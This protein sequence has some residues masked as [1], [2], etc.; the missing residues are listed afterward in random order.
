MFLAPVL[1]AIHA[2]LTGIAMALM[3]AIGVHLG[4][5]FSAG[6]FDYVL[7]YS[8]S[9][10]P[11]LL[12]PVGLAYFALYYGLF[13]FFI[14]RFDLKTLGREAD[15]AAAPR[16]EPAG[17]AAPAYAWINALGSAS[18]LL[19]VEACATRLRLVVARFRA[20]RRARA[21]G[22]RRA[23]RAAPRRWRPAGGG[24]SDRG[25]AR[26]GNSRWTE[27][28]RRRGGASLARCISR[29]RSPNPAPS[30]PAKL[31]QALRALGG[32]ANIV[33]LRLGS[34]RLCLSVRDPAAV[35]EAALAQAVRA[36]ARPAPGQFHLVL[37]PEAP[38][39]FAQMKVS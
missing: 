1:Y 13:R 3:D 18:N 39:W 15:E 35:D 29:P 4:F 37:G 38:S 2:L 7:N 24:W 19:S 6:L 22:T 17:G 9:T 21:Q 26:F 28:R 25:S 31:A 32:R 5:G 16:A 10:R 11:L 30:N 33:E 34:S 23:R 14:V 36:V 27:K 20:H 12:I 8:L